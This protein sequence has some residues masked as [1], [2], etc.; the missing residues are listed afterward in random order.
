M[1]LSS[2]RDNFTPLWQNSVTD[3]SFGFRP[4]CWCHPDGHQHDIYFLSVP[5]FWTLSIE[6]FVIFIW[7]FYEWQDTENQQW[8]VN[9]S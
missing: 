2:S 6:R 9:L 7:I 1:C 3:V 5:R 8:F 4:P